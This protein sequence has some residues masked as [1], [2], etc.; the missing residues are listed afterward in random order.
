[1][2]V[3]GISRHIASGA[4]MPRGAIRRRFGAYYNGKKNKKR[5]DS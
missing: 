2:R 3:S 5:K 4:V 1:M